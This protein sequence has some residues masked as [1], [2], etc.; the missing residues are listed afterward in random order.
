MFDK[1]HM[2]CVFY[3]RVGLVFDTK[4]VYTMYIQ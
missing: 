3:Y 2:L 4:Q 1:R